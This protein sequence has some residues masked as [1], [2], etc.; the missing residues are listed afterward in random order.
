MRVHLVERVDHVDPQQALAWWTDFQPGEHDHA[1]VP[2]AHRRILQDGERGAEILDTVTWLGLTVFRERVHARQRGNTVQLS[3]EN[4][5][6]RFSGRYRFEHVFE[7]EETEAALE[8]TI[9]LKGP[10]AWID[11]LAFPFVRWILRWDTRH[12]ADQMR[13]ALGPDGAA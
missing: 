7:P 8:A 10:L 9:D 1:F 3:G 6:A 11:T 4:T 12:H 13:Q 2:G 5:F